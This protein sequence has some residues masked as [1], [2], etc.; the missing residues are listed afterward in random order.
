MR[1]GWGLVFKGVVRS[2]IVRLDLGW[3]FQGF[4]RTLFDDPLFVL[5]LN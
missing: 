3:C 5:D 4:A 2:H 1:M